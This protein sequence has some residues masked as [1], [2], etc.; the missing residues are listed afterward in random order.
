MRVGINEWN[1]CR[2]EK[3]IGEQFNARQLAYASSEIHSFE[4]GE[5]FSEVYFE[6]WLAP[7]SRYSLWRLL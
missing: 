6:V 4:L 1:S 2:A 7:G 5:P 3:M